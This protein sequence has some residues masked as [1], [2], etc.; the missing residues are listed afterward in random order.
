MG[1]GGMRGG[2]ISVVA[3]K[4][5][6]QPYVDRFTALGTANSNESIEVT[7]RIS[8]V[9]ERIA[10]DEG[11]E[12]KAGD[13]LV[14]LD[15]DE[16][17]ADLAVSQAALQ[18]VAS[19]FARR[20]QLAETRVISEAELEELAAEVAMA[21]AEVR[22]AEARLRNSVIR[23]PF[24][25]TVGLRR[26]SLGD[27]VGPEDVITTLDDTATI[28]L[29]FTVPETYLD[30]MRPGMPIGATTSVYPEKVFAGIVA[31]IDTR[32]DPVT[33]AVRVIAEM[34]NP[35]RIIRPGMFLTIAV[36]RDRDSVLLVPEEALMP[37]QGRQYVYVVEDG[38][39]VEREVAL[40]VRA[41]GLAEI[42]EGLDSGALVITEGAQKV[43]SGM[44]VNVISN[45]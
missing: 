7:A 30:A 40:G 22:A 5:T 1:S 29:E 10:F 21:K 13:L 14:E 25:G 15:N 17:T 18:K 38:K 45:T 26:V 31:H 16:I 33:R 23:A 34:P 3:E 8:S 37:R 27:L 42:R 24:A 41:P 43:R 4:V 20:E 35:E 39:A 12:V 11:Q 28:K 19:Q 6:P 36:E 2:A 32:I 44:P 9:V